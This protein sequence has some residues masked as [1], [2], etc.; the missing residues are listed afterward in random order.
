MTL[1]ERPC[2]ETIDYLYSFEKLNNISQEE[3]DII[4]SQLYSH[5]K[6]FSKEK[7][8]D[9]FYMHSVIYLQ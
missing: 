5:M 9:E 3:L 2:I 4:H 8:I 1:E 6:E 7:N